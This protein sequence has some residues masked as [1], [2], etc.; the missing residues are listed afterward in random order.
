MHNK[1]K[2]TGIDNFIAMVD[3]IELGQAASIK[4]REQ[5]ERSIR[6][7]MIENGNNREALDIATHA[8]EILREVSDEAV[9]QAYKFLEESLN[10]AME[11]MFRHTTRKLR[12]KEWTRG[13]QYPQ[14]ELELT[15]AN[16]EIRSLKSDSG[17]GLAQIVSLLSILS[18]IVITNS[19]RLV[20]M[21]EVISGVS[22]HNRKITTDILWT[23][24]EIGFQFIIN[25]HGYIPQGSQVY[26]MEMVAD[27]S[28]VKETY[29]AEE[30]VYLN[31]TDNELDSYDGDVSTAGFDTTDLVDGIT[32]GNVVSI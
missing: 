9:T 26:H 23:F 24:T 16:G 10:A 31:H 15:V 25:E 4:A 2:F 22:A 6:N 21:D 7:I 1:D 8:I 3:Q 11:R 19:R 14:L 18:L 13:N 27:V 5:L 28:H 30:G 20:V 17:H 12:L 29:I 32:S